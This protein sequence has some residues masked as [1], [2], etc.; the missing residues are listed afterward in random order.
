MR[1]SGSMCS[2]FQMPASAGEMR[3]RA[4]TAVAS[5]ITRPAPPTA[6]LPRWTRCQSLA[7]P[8]TEEYW[9]MGETAMRLRK[10]TSR[11]VRG[12][13][14]LALMFGPQRS[15]SSIFIW[16]ASYLVP[17]TR[18]ASQISSRRAMSEADS[19]RIERPQRVRQLC[20]C[21]R[22]N[23]GNDAAAPA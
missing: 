4:S 8:S 7:N 16:A 11:T 6:R 3:P 13:N 5:I 20:A 17:A 9:H 19:V 10:V 23:H 21:A 1:A 22:A 14:K 12:V 18:A 2:S 15:L